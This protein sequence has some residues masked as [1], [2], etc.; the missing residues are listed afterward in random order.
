MHIGIDALSDVVGFGR[1][2]RNA[3][4]GQN[5]LGHSGL[6]SNNGVIA[7]LDVTDQA[8]LPGHSYIFSYHGTSRDACLGNNYGVFANNYIMGNLDEIINLGAPAND[9][10]VKT[11]PVNSYIGADLNVIFNDYC[12][13]LRNL[14][15]HSPYFSKAKPVAANHCAIMNNYTIADINPL[16]D[17]YIWVENTITAYFCMLANIYSGIENCLISNLCAFFNHTIGLNGYVFT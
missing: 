11:R 16:P 13:N 7:N 2:A 3:C 10:L 6:S 8:C 15:V 9:S 17:R 4:I 14:M 12:A 5:T 1:I